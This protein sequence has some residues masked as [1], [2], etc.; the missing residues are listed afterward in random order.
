MPGLPLSKHK[1]EYI[2]GGIKS[3]Q[4]HPVTEIWLTTHI[5][6]I[7]LSEPPVQALSEPKTSFNRGK[8]LVSRIG[9][10]TYE[11]IT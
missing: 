4:Q 10:N 8:H 1:K 2:S 7:Y 3:R 11:S 6:S 9:D 5:L